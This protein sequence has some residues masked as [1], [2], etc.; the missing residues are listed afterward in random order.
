MLSRLS[1]PENA[2]VDQFTEEVFSKRLV[3]GSKMECVDYVVLRSLQ[4]WL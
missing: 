3:A 1:V 2:L 4:A